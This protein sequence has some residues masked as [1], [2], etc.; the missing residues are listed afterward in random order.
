MIKLDYDI[1]YPTTSAPG[2]LTVKGE[3]I[4]FD[5][6]ADR[7]LMHHMWEQRLVVSPK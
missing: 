6:S 5:S 4:Q 3:V 1:E 2:K 7:D